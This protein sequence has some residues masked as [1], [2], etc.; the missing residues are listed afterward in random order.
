MNATYVWLPIVASPDSSVPGGFSFKMKFLE[1][2][3]ISTSSSK[4]HYSLI[5][6]FLYIIFAD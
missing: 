4:I 2:W 1:K 3:A 6:T 5:Y